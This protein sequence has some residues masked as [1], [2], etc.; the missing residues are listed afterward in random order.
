MKIDWAIFLEELFYA[1][2]GAILLFAFLEM[3]WPGIIL[4]YFNLNYLLLPW[5]LNGIII[6]IIPYGKQR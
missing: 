2:T 4:A 6:L 5:L 3:A 1:L